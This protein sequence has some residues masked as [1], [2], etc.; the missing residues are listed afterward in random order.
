MTAAVLA[1]V[2]LFALFPL[3][4][5]TRHLS[6]GAVPGQAAIGAIH[7]HTNRSDGSGSVDDVA[8]AAANAGLQFVVI[9]DHGD[10][11]RAPDPPQYRSGVLIIDA[12]ELSTSNGHYIA[13]GLRP[14]PYPLR[15]EARDVVDDVKR[16]GGFGIVAHPHSAKVNLQWRDWDAPFDAL[17]WLNA[18]SEWRDESTVSLARALLRYALRPSETLA[19]LLDRPDET[20]EQ[21]DD[22]LQRRRVVGVAGADAHARIGS[23]EEDASSYRGNWA[24][25]IPSY[26]ASF[27]TFTTHVE[28]EGPLSRDPHA[29]A[30][31]IISGLKAGRSYSSINALATPATISFT[32]TLES[33][34]RGF[35]CRPHERDGR[36]R[37]CSAERQ[38]YRCAASVARAEVSLERAGDISQS[39]S[40][41]RTRPVTRR[42]RGL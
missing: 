16:L 24:L 20:L 42:C 15:G 4:E 7:I 39:R 3:P 10:G 18:D 23:T 35:I 29:A 26:E 14:S 27:R 2:F 30:T 41:C 21:W 11:T 12:V 25:T 13:I 6:G 19:S 38:P 40:I 37:D 33:G 32:H 34:R 8:A 17:E 22:L 5:P 31:Q 9:T 28:T 1:A 36:G